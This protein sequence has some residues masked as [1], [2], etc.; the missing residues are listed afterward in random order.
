M[1]SSPMGSSPFHDQVHRKVKA[2]WSNRGW[3]LTP[4]N[5]APLLALALAGCSTL[6]VSMPTDIDGAPSRVTVDLA[7]LPDAV[8]RPE[9]RAARG[10]PPFYEVDG[11]RYFVM[12]S[13]AGHVE[14]GIASWYGTK[15]HGRQTSS[16]EP[17]DMFAMTAAHR[18]L[19]LPSY[20]RVTN[21]EN[22]R[23]VVVRIND[24]GPF[25]HN[26]AIDLS[27]AAATRLDI[28]GPGT[29]LVKIEV[30]DPGAPADTGPKLEPGPAPRLF[31]QVGA[32]SS[33]DNAERVMERL[34]AAH[35]YNVELSERGDQSPA[36]WRVRAGPLADV[37]EV[38]RVSARITDIGFPEAR[39]V[40]D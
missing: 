21:L 14:R 30:L 9:P 11:Q 19:P 29:G 12:E 26:R 1:G 3:D 20:A 34:R 39:I 24:R 32:F 25:A 6:P 17:Y 36:L 4:R 2:L 35:I 5:L 38:D 15:F 37:D 10:N 8:P 7:K 18:H 31:V 27:Y 16:G 23:T 28:V 13:G 40:I 22:G 33:R